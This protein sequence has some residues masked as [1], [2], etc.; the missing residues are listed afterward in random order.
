MKVIE[1]KLYP[2]KTCL[3]KLEFTHEQARLLYNEALEQRI[4]SWEEN[5]KGLSYY[6]QANK[7]TNL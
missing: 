6:D 3:A 7:G 5:K 2:N 1:Y 4:T